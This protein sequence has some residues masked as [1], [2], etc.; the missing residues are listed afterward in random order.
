M[1]L[2]DLIQRLPNR[3]G[4]PR[5]R[6]LLAAGALGLI[7]AAAIPAP[8]DTPRQPLAARS[9][10]AINPDPVQWL[11]LPADADQPE[12]R[13]I[14]IRDIDSPGDPDVLRVLALR[15]AGQPH[16][17]AVSTSEVEMLKAYADE[18]G[19]ELAWVLVDDRWDL[20]PALQRG[21]G[22]LIAGQDEAIQA[23]MQSRAEFTLP[24]TTRRQHVV[25]RRGNQSLTGLTDLDNRQVAVKTGSPAYT[26][27]ADYARERPAMEVVRI[28]ADQHATAMLRGLQTGRY[29]LAV[30]D[31]GSLAEHLSQYP[32]LN[33]LFDLPGGERLV[34][35]VHPDN[36]DLR[37]AVDGFLS[38]EAL[39]RGV[40]D[41]RFEDLPR[42]EERRTLRVI[43]YHSQFNYYMDDSGELRGFEYELMRKFAR[44]RGLRVEMVVAPSQAAM[45]RWLLEGRGDLIAASVPTAVTRDDEQLTASRPYNYA[46][47]LVVGRQGNES[48]IDARDLEGRRIVV[49]AGSPHKRLLKR[50]QQRGIGVDVVEADPDQ[51][52]ADILHRVEVGIYDLT[53]VDSHK[54]RALLDAEPG[55]RVLFAVSEPLPHS[56]IMRADDSQLLN[57]VNNFIADTYRQRD[58]NVLHARYFEHPLKHTAPQNSTSG[59]LL[60]L[61]GELSPYDDL[62]Q[63]YAE[64]FGFDW[65]LIVAQMYQESRFD[66]HAVSDAGAIGLMQ[67][68]PTTANELGISEL[69]EPDAAIHAGVRY[70]NTLH[71]RL[72]DELAFEDRVWFSLAA[73]NAGFQ[74]LEQARQRAREMGLDPDRWFDNVE[75]AM[76]TMA[77]DTACRCGQPV[78]YVREI[79]ARYHNYVRLIQATQFAARSERGQRHG[80]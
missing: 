75:E 31:S 79:R 28:P 27:L 26:V 4:R 32:R 70:L 15:E 58:Y 30:L 39:S 74:R 13:G 16:I 44:Q 60:A 46:A 7:A 64:Q 56:W 33:T 42:I 24:W 61:G 11:P 20:L 41:V 78:V 35:G 80:I 1:L 43:T 65:R 18:A 49:P 50:Y 76:L 21:R 25:G 71:Q 63:R 22:D 9:A 37:D 40:A 51:S 14:P 6:R 59:E 66:P 69:Y 53:V 48:L 3:H 12:F 62:V 55:T 52:I 17:P 73:Y 5:R 57:A 36:D 45:V 23:G 77:D 19:H 54:S 8:A 34:W 67:L 38:R 47:P 2:N 72:E 68:L 29:D 10:P